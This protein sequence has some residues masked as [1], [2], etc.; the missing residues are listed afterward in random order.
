MHDDYMIYSHSRAKL[1]FFVLSHVG[2]CPAVLKLF[3]FGL[4]QALFY[5]L[6]YVSVSY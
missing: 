3:S 2:K 6:L 5:C 4:F 1:P